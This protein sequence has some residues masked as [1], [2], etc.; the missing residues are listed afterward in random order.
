MIEVRAERGAEAASTIAGI[1]AAATLHAGEHE[2]RV[3]VGATRLTLGPMWRA[4]GSELC[5]AA[6]SE[7]GACTLRAS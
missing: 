6:L 1:K 4:D 2:L 3:L 5:M 7:F